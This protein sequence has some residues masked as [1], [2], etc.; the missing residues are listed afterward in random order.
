MGYLIDKYGIPILFLINFAFWLMY[1]VKN[2]I[3]IENHFVNSYIVRMFNVFLTIFSIWS[4]FTLI[5]VILP[6]SSRVIIWLFLWSILCIF[7]LYF[8]LST[9]FNVVGVKN[10]YHDIFIII[11]ALVSIPIILAA[12]FKLDYK[13]H[14]IQ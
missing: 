4:I 2:R 3:L 9:L 10:K 7:E 14:T 13:E 1:Y 5:K 11:I 6:N 8:I 12:I